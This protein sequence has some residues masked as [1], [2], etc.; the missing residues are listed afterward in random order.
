MSLVH[1]FARIFGDLRPYIGGGFCLL[2][3]MITIIG[4]VGVLRFPDFYT[5]MHA[6]SVTETGAALS[7][8]LG[9]ALL[10]P[11]WLVLIKLITVG[12]FL[13]LTGPTASHAIV[14][15]AHIAGLEPIIGRVGA[16]ADEEVAE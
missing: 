16:H 13:F 4:A 14:N 12:L 8:L 2:G 6:A 5:R 15:A 1:E 3:G 11:D 7:L 10:S 9:M